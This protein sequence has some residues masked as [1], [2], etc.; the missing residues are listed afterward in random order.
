MSRRES[1]NA[2]AV[3][4][5]VIWCNSTGEHLSYADVEEVRSDEYLPVAAYIA[6]NGKRRANHDS[7][8][9]EA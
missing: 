4:G 7:Y 2:D 3:V 8:E 1:K 9:V 5:D 6:A